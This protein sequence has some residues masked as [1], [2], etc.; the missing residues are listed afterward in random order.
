MP[1]MD[2][3]KATLLIRKFE[4]E[5]RHRRSTIVALTASVRESA[6]GPEFDEVLTKPLSRKR[7][8]S[9]LHW[10][11]EHNTSDKGQGGDG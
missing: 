9:M 4:E 6:S 5:A 10:V 3:K 2:G 11:F 8:R 1:V 7:L